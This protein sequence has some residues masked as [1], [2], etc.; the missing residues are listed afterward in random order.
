MLSDEIIQLVKSSDKFCK[1]FHIPLQ[2]G[3]T[4]ILKK[5]KRR[6]NTELYENLIM[7]LNEEIPGIGIGVD[8]IVGFPGETYSNFENTLNFI[9]SLQVSYLHVFSYSER[10][11]TFAISL[12]VKVDVVKRKQ[13]SLIL[14]ELSLKKKHEFY[15]SHYGKK[16]LVLF[17]SLKENGF[18]SGFTDN[19]IKI[20]MKG[21]D[22]ME[23][24]I[25]PVKILEAN[26][27][28]YCNAELTTQA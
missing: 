21:S 28:N 11:D 14:R 4:E 27:A 16:K 23:N 19:Y 18:I 24:K 26:S 15:K 5:M 22:E 17:E 12:P 9:E 10:K 1:H 20:K 13:R 7:K 3:D 25:L 8:V 2:S 6:Y